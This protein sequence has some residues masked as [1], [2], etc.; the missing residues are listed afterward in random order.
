MTSS[1]TL[2]RP[3]ELVEAGLVSPERLAELERVAAHYAVAIT[4]SMAALVDLADPHD[5]IARQFVPDPAE[6]DVQPDETTDPIGDR[7]HSPVEGLV[8]RYSDRVLLKLVNV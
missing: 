1:H 4:P 7:A 3:A 2:R 8:H 5:P 6:L